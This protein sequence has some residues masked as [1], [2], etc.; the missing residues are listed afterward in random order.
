MNARKGFFW[1]F[2]TAIIVT[3]SSLSTE[4]SN[5]HILSHE[6]SHECDTQNNTISISEVSLDPFPPLRG[7]KNLIATLGTFMT[8]QTLKSLSLEAYFLGSLIYSDEMPLSG[9]YKENDSIELA[10]PFNIP[11]FAPFGDYTVYAFVINSNNEKINCWQI[12]LSL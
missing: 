12:S 6:L 9:T 5:Q 7:K 10:Y 1:F 3:C 4:T 11:F 2:T 8:A